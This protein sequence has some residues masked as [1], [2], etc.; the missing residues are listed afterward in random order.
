MRIFIAIF[1]FLLTSSCSSEVEP[2]KQFSVSAVEKQPLKIKYIRSFQFRNPSDATVIANLF[3]SFTINN[4]GSRLAFYDLL[5]N[6]IVITDNIGNLLFIVGKQ[7]KGPQEFID[8]SS[9]NFDDYDNLIIFDQGQRMVKIFDQ[10]GEHI[11]SVKVFSNEEL[12]EYSRIL[13]ARDSLIYMGVLEARYS[14][15]ENIEDSKLIGVLDYNGKLR[16]L[17]GTYD[18]YV[19]LATMYT[20]QPIFDI[21]FQKRKIYSSHMN[22]YRIQIFNLKANNRLA[23]FGYKSPH[24]IESAEEISPFAPKY[25]RREMALNQSFTKGLY[26]TD[27]YILLYF[28]N[29]T[30]KWYKTRSPIDKEYFISIFDKKKHNFIGEIRLPF[31]LGSVHNNR[32][33]LVE[34]NNPDNYTVGI[35][36]LLEE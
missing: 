4:D 1:L 8:I 17:I 29:L 19:T 14:N 10:R 13:F 28:Y 33:Y 15:F 11:K 5:Y 23:Y 16:K 24:F 25:K 21:D 20:S 7:G 18:P 2:I 12:L 27:K 34:N 9:W 32:L 3:S 26:V 30:E 6:H 35:Y 31:S 22:S 36:E